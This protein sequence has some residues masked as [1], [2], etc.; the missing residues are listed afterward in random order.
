MASGEVATTMG[1]RFKN[2]KFLLRADYS[3]HPAAYI[4]NL[5]SDMT[6]FLNFVLC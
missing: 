4:N 6:P 3:E 5:P 2:A 1:E